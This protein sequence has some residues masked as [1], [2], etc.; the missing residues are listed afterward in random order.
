MT[1]VKPVLFA[2]VCVGR[3]YLNDPERTAQVL[4][5]GGW[6]STGDLG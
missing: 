3:G 1:I 6:L 5:S 2:G 4:S